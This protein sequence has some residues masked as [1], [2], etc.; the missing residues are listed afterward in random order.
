[1]PVRKSGKTPGKL[2]LERLIAEMRE[3]RSVLAERD[4]AFLD[5]IV[6][7]LQA[8]QVFEWFDGRGYACMPILLACLEA[9]ELRRTFAATLKRSQRLLS[10][11]NKKQNELERLRASVKQLAKFVEQEVANAPSGW[12]PA[13]TN[14]T[15]AQ[16]TV[17]RTGLTMIN[18]EVRFLARI[19]EESPGRI[20][21]TRK[22]KGQAATK[23]AIGWLAEGVKRV[24]GA[25]NEEVVAELVD[26]VLGIESTVDQVH[27]ARRVR[28]REWRKPLG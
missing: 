26:V 16:V 10:K 15:P 6:A 20:G 1:M 7:D 2:I 19:A 22:S 5:R 28:K 24:T 12:L 11:R 21:A 8:G 9:H 13:R 27:E 14:T 23:A 17:M 25:A 4:K 18:D 3:H